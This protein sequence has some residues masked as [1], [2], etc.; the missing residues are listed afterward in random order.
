MPADGIARD[1][2]GELI[3]VAGDER[4]GLATAEAGDRPDGED[5][6]VGHGVG[7]VSQVVSTVG[8]RTAIDRR[9]GHGTDAAVGGEGADVH[10]R[11]RSAEVDV[12]ELERGK[13]ARDCTE[14]E[15]GD[16]EAARDAITGLDRTA[17][18]DVDRAEERAGTAEDGVVGDVGRDVRAGATAKGQRATVDIDRDRAGEGAGRAHREGTG[19]ALDELADA[20]TIDGAAEGAVRAHGELTVEAEEDRAARGAG[21]FKGGDGLGRAVEVELGARDVREADDGVGREIPI[22]AGLDRA[23][24]DRGLDGV[25]LGGIEGPHP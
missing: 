19:A 14:D 18:G 16:G 21:T 3:G 24:V 6:E 20:R 8:E 17:I 1:E 9:D 5:R 13:I 11:R 22:C 15:V 10:D 25:G 2:H 12:A 4:A 23:A 7:E